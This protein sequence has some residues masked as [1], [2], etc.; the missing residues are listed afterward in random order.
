MLSASRL[1]AHVVAA[2]VCGEGDA[3]AVAEGGVGDGDATEVR[4]AAADADA[5][6]Q[7]WLRGGGD[8]EA[9]AGTGGRTEGESV[10]GNGEGIPRGGAPRRCGIAGL[11]EL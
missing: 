5:R 3:G 4:C 8:D 9:G 7:G 1:S 6:L 2:G 11:R 10:V